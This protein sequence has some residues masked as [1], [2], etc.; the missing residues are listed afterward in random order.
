MARKSGSTIVQEELYPSSAR[1]SREEAAREEIDDARLVDL[2]VAEESPFLRGQKRI[3]ARRS[4]LPKKAALSL[5]WIALGLTVLCL[6]TVAAAILYNYGEHSWRFRVE[7]SDNI[8]INGMENV[9]KP[10]IME[11]MG[12]DIGRNIFFI[13]LAQQKAQLEQIPWVESASVMR[14][15][16]NRLSVEI[17]ER[18]PVAF[19]R[20]GPRIEL[21]DAGGTLMEL[22]QKHRYSFP[23]ILGMN[24]G[25]PLST[26]APR[27]RVYNEMVEELDSGGARYS[28]DLSEVDLTDLEDLKVRVNDPAG[29]VLVHLGSAD[30]LHRY[31]IYVGHVQEWRQQFQKLESVDLR[32]DNQIIVNPD[33][34]LPGRK[35]A[36][37]TP[38]A[39]R[40]AKAAGV[41]TA[42][43]TS[44][45]GPHDRPIPKPAFELPQKKL[46]ANVAANA[47]KTTATKTNA[48]KLMA[49]KTSATKKPAANLKASKPKAK[50]VSQPGKHPATVAV[51]NAA[52]AKNPPAHGKAG[53]TI[54]KMN[55]G[56]HGKN[57]PRKPAAG[58]PLASTPAHTGPPKPSPAIAKRPDSDIT[59]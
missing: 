23:V 59:N 51:K 18:T 8:E 46:D 22:P 1:S 56:T 14:F 49:T 50:P 33:M 53:T 45:I 55:A 21:I 32:Y 9:T 42:A 5:K 34:E 52:V 10:Q 30:Y 35:R 4:S 54:T 38:A 27:M 28:Q 31:K 58:K 40:A 11:V 25:E 20:V 29:D 41:K 6:G 3:S 15:V 39:A 24:P 7:S 2:D 36:V 12:A 43:L 37:L 19:A 44:R 17:H 26:R 16:P 47:T 13:P 48:T 57:P